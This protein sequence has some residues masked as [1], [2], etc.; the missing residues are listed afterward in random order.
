MNGAPNIGY[1]PWHGD[2]MERSIVAVARNAAPNTTI[3]GINYRE[4]VLDLR[5][6]A[7]DA[8]SLDAI[9]QQLRAA[10]WQADIKDLTASGD[11]YRG[12]LQIRK[13]GA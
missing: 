5:V 10:S 13:A 1:A 11:S 3:E 7:P 9:S 2:V 6:I 4:G 8:A 12:R